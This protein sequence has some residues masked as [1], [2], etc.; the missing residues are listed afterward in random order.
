M[1]IALTDIAV[2]WHCLNGTVLVELG[3]AVLY[4]LHKSYLYEMYQ[5]GNILV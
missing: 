1:K 2:Y 4:I 5:Q 3:S